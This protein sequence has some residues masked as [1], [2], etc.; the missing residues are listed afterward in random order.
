MYRQALF[1]QRQH[2]AQFYTSN[3]QNGLSDDDSFAGENSETQGIRISDLVSIDVSSPCPTE[4]H[5]YWP[6]AVRDHTNPLGPVDY[7][8]DIDE[9]PEYDGQVNV[10]GNKDS[11]HGGP[12]TCAS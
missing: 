12:E 8:D 7:G 2:P 11:L 4:R 3:D 5:T 9:H 10:N 6:S 1:G